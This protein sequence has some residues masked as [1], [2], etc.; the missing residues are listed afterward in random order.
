MGKKD[1]RMEEQDSAT[2]R[3]EVKVKGLRKAESNA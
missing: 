1:I 2:T 3:K